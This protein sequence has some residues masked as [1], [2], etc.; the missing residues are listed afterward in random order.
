MNTT[1]TTTV[2]AACIAAGLGLAACGSEE[3]SGDIATLTLTNTGADPITAVTLFGDLDMEIEVDPT[4][5][6]EATLRV[7]DNLVDNIEAWIDDDGELFV[8]WSDYVVD[9]EPSEQ[10]VLILSVQDLDAVENRSDGTI[11]VRGADR[12]D[13]EVD[14]EGDGDIEVLA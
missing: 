11:T 9:V 5:T 7:D 1:T 3:G 14:N 13:L 6:Q 10:P 8:G 12:A 4:A 2:L